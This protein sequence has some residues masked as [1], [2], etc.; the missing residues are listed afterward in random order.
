MKCHDVLLID[1]LVEGVGPHPRRQRRL[2]L[3]LLFSVMVKKH[4]WPTI[5]LSSHSS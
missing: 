5:R 4:F 2:T 1:E 3:E